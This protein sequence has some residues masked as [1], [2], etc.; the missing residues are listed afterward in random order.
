MALLDGIRSIRDLDLENKKLFLRVDFNCPL[1][2][3]TVTDDSRIR[4]ALPSIRHAMSRGARV[5]LASHLGRPS[6]EAG[7]DNSAFSLEPCGARLAELL[8]AEVHMPDES[9]GP[10]PQKILYDLRAGQVCLLPNLRLQAEEEANDEMFS[11]ALASLAD[12]YV[13]DAFGAAHRAHASTQGMARYFKERGYG[14]LVEKELAGLLPLLDRPAAPYIA[15]LGGSKVSDKIDVIEALLSKVKTLL[16]G[17]AMANTFLVAKGCNMQSSK[18][19]SDKLSLARTLLE[20]AAARNVTVMLPTDVVVA[21]SFKATTGT[22]ALVDALPKGSIALDIGP[23][24]RE[25]YVR[26][27]ASARTMFW[28]GPMGLFERAA[29]AQGSFAIARAMAASTGFTVVGGGD[30][31]AAVHAAG[32]G[33]AAAISH[34]STGGGAALELIEGKRLPGIE[35]L[36]GAL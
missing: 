24:T 28:N 8:N 22:V 17:G 26:E 19:E 10:L 25:A 23:A 4:E 31:A 30:S 11:K 33:V 16:I 15:A 27:V 20:K 29:F 32:Q 13:N 1:D 36:R 5:V 9:T 34:I 2:G 6:H 14:L 21:D 35:V 7:A 18:V 3:S 12:V